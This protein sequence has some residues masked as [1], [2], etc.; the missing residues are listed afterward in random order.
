MCGLAKALENTKISHEFEMYLS[1]YDKSSK[2]K[3]KIGGRRKTGK[4]F[5]S[6]YPYTHIYIY[7][8]L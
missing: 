8:C 2:N 7:I 3:K 5:H 1:S 4:S 6:I